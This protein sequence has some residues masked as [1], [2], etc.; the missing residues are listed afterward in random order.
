[1]VL[2]FLASRSFITVFRLAVTFVSTVHLPN[3]H[4]NTPNTASSCTHSRCPKVTLHRQWSAVLWLVWTEYFVICNSW[5]QST[6]W[7]AI[8]TVSVAPR[9]H[10]LLVGGR[11]SGSVTRNASKISVKQ[12]YN[13]QYCKD[14]N[15]LLLWS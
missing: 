5:Q 3:K 10:F 13:I 2:H 8:C 6:T 11:K 15:N 14:S 1:M 9:C 7:T 4:T 12:P